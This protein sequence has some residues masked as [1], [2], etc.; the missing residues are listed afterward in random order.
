MVGVINTE[1]LDDS[2]LDNSTQLAERK[3]DI[4]LL[5]EFI[6]GK[7]TYGKNDWSLVVH[8][9]GQLR[10]FIT[11]QDWVKSEKESKD[12]ELTESMVSYLKN[13]RS[14]NGIVEA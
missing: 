10:S 1:M 14:L 12:R 3:V 5:N 9:V 4:S 7:L 2:E 13:V 8:H 11:Q 6:G